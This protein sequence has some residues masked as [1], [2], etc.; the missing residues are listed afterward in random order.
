MGYIWSV[1]IRAVRSILKVENRKVTAIL[2]PL[3]AQGLPLILCNTEAEEYLGE[4]GLSSADVVPFYS[5][6]HLWCDQCV[7]GRSAWAL[8]DP[9]ASDSICFWCP[10]SACGLSRSCHAFDCPWAR[11]IGSLYLGPSLIWQCFSRLGPARSLKSWGRWLFDQWAPTWAT[12][13]VEKL[14]YKNEQLFLAVLRQLGEGP[15]ERR[16]KKLRL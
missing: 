15:R 11:C 3:G 7:G 4:E 13:A 9:H 8:A 16:K 12:K 6:L 2:G 14:V 10:A 5:L 1:I